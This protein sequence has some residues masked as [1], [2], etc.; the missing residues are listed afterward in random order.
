MKL[1]RTLVLPI[2]CAL[3]PAAA[4]AQSANYFDRNNNVGVLDRPRP[5]YQALGIQAGSFY[6]F[7]TLTIAPEYDDNIF[8][9]SDD[10]IGDLI[11]AVSPAVQVRSDWS[12]NAA[13]FRAQS[14]SDIYAIHGGENTTDY[15]FAGSGRLDIGT[16][17]NLSAQL[18]YGRAT[19]PRTSDNA[20]TTTNT[21]VQY[22][23]T[24]ATGGG[25]QTLNRVR[26]TESVNFTR[27]VYDNTQ[28]TATGPLSLTYLNGDS[29]SASLRTDYAL[30][31]EFSV[32]VSGQ[33]NNRSY[34]LKPP[35]VPLDRNSTGYEVLTG[36]SFDITRLVRG[37]LGVGYLQQDYKSYTVSGPA[38]NGN[39]E[40]FLSGLTT[41]TLSGDRSVIDAIN[42]SAV[43]LLQT[44]GSVTVDHELLR[45]V[46]ISLRASYE[47]DTFTG[48]QRTDDRASFSAS[49]AYLLNR[50]VSLHLGYSFLNQT[51]TGAERGQDFD[52][53]VISLSLVLQL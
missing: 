4:M 45:N 26:F 9:T 49:G 21:P 12:R 33:V 27:A 29:E 48:E 7:P 36:A 41:I 51:S 47:T 14:T 53:N 18:S 2:A 11:T 20:I 35:Q 39:I 50:Y 19:I 5:D 43:S 40:Y 13:S 44:R 52:V 31:P 38:V 22:D 3:A 6:I 37:Q 17:S 15:S 30:N 28:Q 42:P 24:S 16:A 10:R 1:F 34:D 23:S 8:A 25:V 32:Y 46:I